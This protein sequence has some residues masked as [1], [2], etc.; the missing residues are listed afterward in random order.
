MVEWNIQ[1]EI[2]GNSAV[3]VK[4]VKDLNLSTKTLCFRAEPDEIT[5]SA[6]FARR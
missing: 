1:R 6:A 2:H 5:L 3:L 4:D